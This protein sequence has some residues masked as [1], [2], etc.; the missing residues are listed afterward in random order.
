MCLQL[1]GLFPC[2]LG[3]RRLCTRL[4]EGWTK[5]YSGL[6]EKFP[7]YPDHDSLSSLFAASPTRNDIDCVSW[8]R[9]G[10]V[11]A[12]LVQEGET[13]CQRWCLVIERCKAWYLESCY[14]GPLYSAQTGV[15]VNNVAYC[16]HKCS[17]SNG[18][19][20]L[21]YFT[22]LYSTLLFGSTAVWQPL[23]L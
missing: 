12:C 16:G 3:S 21:L 7:F 22:L 8:H 4:S 11:T 18:Q 10:P 2:I 14:S 6:H 20:T 5:D 13:A 19:N 9:N 17:V 23:P 1:W 15:V